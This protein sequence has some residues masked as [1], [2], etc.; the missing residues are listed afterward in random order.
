[1]IVLLKRIA[2]FAVVFCFFIGGFKTQGLGVSAKSAIL[3]DGISGRVIYCAN[4]K[5]RLSMASTT[6]IMTALLLC[7]N[8]EFDKEITITPEMVR[9]EG[10]SMG[11]SVGMKLTHR[12]LLYGMLL[13]SGNDAANATAVSIGGS[14]EDFVAMMNKKAEELGLSDT[15]FDTPS[16]L[17]GDTHYTTAYDLVMLTRYALTN[18]DFS[19]V[20]QTKSI[21]LNYGGTSHTLTNHNRLLFSY[22]GAVGVK[23][24]FTK[25]SGR[26]LVSAARRDNALLIAVTLNDGNDWQD[27][28]SMLDYGFTFISDNPVLF[29]KEN[30]NVSVLGGDK[31]SVAAKC[32]EISFR[33]HKEST[34]TKKE[35]VYP[36]VYAPIQKGDTVGYIEYYSGDFLVVS[37]EIIAEENVNAVLPPTF[38]QRVK[39]SFCMLFKLI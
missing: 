29:E 22:E 36:F 20:C 37:Q 10:S 14:I 27:H 5:Q 32:E 34:I 31:E 33:T 25:K 9:T 4:E 38:W 11:L 7:E 39:V 26:C 8:G 2:V 35:Y 23:T 17:D 3:M 21:T 19:E 6:K 13:T 28:K 1:M 15:H 18:E 12:D 16:G 30:Y 24:G